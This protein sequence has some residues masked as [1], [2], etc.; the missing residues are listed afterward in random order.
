MGLDMYLT[1][2]TYI[3]A[4]Y[5]HRGVEGEIDL[6]RQSREEQVPIKIDVSRVSEITEEF[7]YWRKFNALH[8]W[9]VENC[10]G[11]VDECQKI[12]LSKE[13]LEKLLSIVKEVLS[14]KEK[15]P[16]LLSTKSGF[17]FGPTDY[18]EW[19]MKNLRYTEEVLEKALDEADE[20]W[21]DFY[22]RAS[23]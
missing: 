17:F 1:K 10:A 22:Y 9:F 19:Y 15:A 23:W 5:K 14:D 2:E 16:D 8:N 18:G 12:Y 11:G 7:A 3:G 13:T 21:V 6:T 20:P 4:Q